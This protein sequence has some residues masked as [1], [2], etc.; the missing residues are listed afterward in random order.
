MCREDSLSDDLESGAKLSD[1]SMG[2]GKS[3]PKI[4]GQRNAHVVEFDGPDDPWNPQNWP[5]SAKY[6]A[7]PD[8]KSLTWLTAS[9]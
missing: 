1:L 8:I 3:L 2:G 7:F 5:S 4:L 9:S 6:E